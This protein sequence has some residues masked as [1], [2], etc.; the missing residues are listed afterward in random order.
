MK[1]KNYFRFSP[2]KSIRQAG[3]PPGHRGLRNRISPLAASIWLKCKLECA[4][5]VTKQSS[6]E[7]R[8]SLNRHQLNGFAGVR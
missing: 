5:L 8:K 4:K 2:K 3:T 1:R 7:K 6:V